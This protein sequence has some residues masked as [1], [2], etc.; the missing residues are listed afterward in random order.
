MNGFGGVIKFTQ[1]PG[2]CKRLLT[3]EWSLKSIISGEIFRFQYVSLPRQLDT[4][5]FVTMKRSYKTLY[6]S[7]IL[8]LGIVSNTIA[9]PAIQWE[10]T[11]HN[12]GEVIEGDQAVHEFSFTNSGDQPLVISRV[13]ASCGCTTPFWTREPVMPGEKGVIKASYNSKGRPG[14]FRKSITVTS[15]AATPTS[16]VFIQ[17]VVVKRP[18]TAEE[19]AASSKLVV[20][21]A[22]VKTGKIEKGQTVPVAFEISNEGKAAL[23]FSNVRSNC[24]CVFFDPEFDRSVGSGEAHTLKLMYTPSQTGNWVEVV[25]L[26]TN[27]VSNREMKITISAEVVENLSEEGMGSRRGF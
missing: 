25:T 8:F 21:Q 7:T 15:N 2:F 17:G 10:E 3:I 6:F 14:N 22:T 1:K 12:F 5:H 9:Q 11:N 19:I 4:K 18:P 16:A 23:A 27:D 20:E 13:Q 26:Y 24:N